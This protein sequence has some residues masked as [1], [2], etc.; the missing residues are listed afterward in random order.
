MDLSAA[1]PFVCTIARTRPRRGRTRDYRVSNKE[2]NPRTAGG[3]GRGSNR[4]DLIPS[5]PRDASKENEKKKKKKK[6]RETPVRLPACMNHACQRILRVCQR[7]V[8]RMYVSLQ[9]CLCRGKRLLLAAFS[10][11]SCP[12]K[13]HA[14]ATVLIDRRH[15]N[16]HRRARRYLTTCSRA[17]ARSCLHLRAGSLLTSRE[18]AIES[19]ATTNEG[20]ERAVFSRGISIDPGSCVRS[21]ARNRP[22][23]GWVPPPPPS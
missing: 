14:R 11:P 15:A 7:N 6:R 12:Y 8:A 1:L 5:I 22:D 18:L 19:T 3:G 16:R 21:C 20:K 17:I 23:R 13:C 2:S 9:G 10:R 4:W